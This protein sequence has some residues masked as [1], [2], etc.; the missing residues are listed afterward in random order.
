MATEELHEKNKLRSSLY[1]AQADLKNEHPSQTE[2][3][4]YGA[5]VTQESKESCTAE[6]TSESTS[7]LNSSGSYLKEGLP[8]KQKSTSFQGERSSA[9]CLPGEAFRASIV[10]QL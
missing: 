2:S 7:T 9:I 8:E 4:T 3:S 10:K 6:N 5:Q 1:D